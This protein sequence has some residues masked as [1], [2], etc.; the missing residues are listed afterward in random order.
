ML[1]FDRT[2]D[3]P[4]GFSLDR[5]D[6]VVRRTFKRR[7]WRLILTLPLA[8]IALAMFIQYLMGYAALIHKGPIEPIIVERVPTP[9]PP[10]RLADAPPLPDAAAIAKD[11]PIVLELMSDRAEVRHDDA[12]DGLTMAWA[13][14]LMAGDRTSAPIP[15][16]VLARDLIFGAINPGGAVAIH[17][18]LVDS[19]AAP[20]AGGDTW[21]RL[22][23]E[24][25]E[26]Q[27]VQVLTG[28]E[29]AD[30][31]IGRPVQAVGRYLGLAPLPT[32]TEGTT[33][34]PLL[35]VRAIRPDNGTAA[36]LVPDLAEMRTGIPGPIVAE[37][38]AHVSDE[39]SVLEMRPY[40]L[41]LGQA[42]ADLGI[43][44]DRTIA[45]AVNGNA[46]ADAIH[47][48]P[49]AARGKPF[50]ITGFVYRTWQDVHV[51]RD[52]PYGLN[53]VTR[54]LLW[55]RDFGAVT[56]IIDGKKHIKSQILRL[57]ELCLIGDQPVPERGAQIQ[58]DCRF[59]KF[60][61]IPVQADSLRDSRNNVHRQSH[62]VYTFTFVGSGF[63]EIPPPPP[64]EP[65]WF[66]AVTLILAGGIALLIFILRRRDHRQEALTGPQIRR[67]RETR[68]K[69]DRPAGP[70]NS[71]PATAPAA[72]AASDEAAPTTIVPT[73][74]P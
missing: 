45:G 53:Q 48:D 56:E 72:S 44:P 9:T 37:D 57:Y 7:E 4:P 70:A 28:P 25:D 35:A 68:R 12:L 40:Y 49:S 67:L 47:Q 26:Q 2:K 63:R 24:L 32:G 61:A 51:S 39:R 42:K 59:F 3:P 33:L 65:G 50:T 34:V 38:F 41:L 19:V 15:Q 54:I 62:Y 16:Q 74:S 52:Q 46:E 8:L 23:I 10:P 6:L 20:I 17:G 43:A 5:R 31:V 69:L 29:A 55:N 18:R 58:A 71:T 64:Y 73:P 60:R 36:D 14:A 22:A 11:R 13:E 27:V 30:L 1:R 21:Q 66:D